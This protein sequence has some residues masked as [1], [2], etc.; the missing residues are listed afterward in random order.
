MTTNTPRDRTE[1]EDSSSGRVILLLIAA[2]VPLVASSH[3]IDAQL[4]VLGVVLFALC[5]VLS[6]IAEIV[7]RRHPAEKPL[8]LT[9]EMHVVPVAAELVDQRHDPVEHGAVLVVGDG[10]S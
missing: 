1:S 10:Q 8:R 6:V 2:M 5:G 3:A 7:D 9:A 4:P